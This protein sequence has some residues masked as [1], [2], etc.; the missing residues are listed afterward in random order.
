[1][2][3]SL[4]ANPA[5]KFFLYASKDDPIVPAGAFVDEARQR[6]T[7]VQ[8]RY[9]KDSAHDGFL[10]EPRVWKDLDATAG[11]KNGGRR[12]LLKKAKPR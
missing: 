12:R 1:M 4:Q 3:R 9:L 11:I 8:F 7:L 2:I 10:T 5:L 6:G